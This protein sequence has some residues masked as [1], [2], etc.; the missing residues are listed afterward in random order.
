MV[1][2]RKEAARLR[3]WTLQL[4]CSQWVEALMVSL[5]DWVGKET[6]AGGMALLS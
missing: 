4:L 1:V 6:T 5:T 3:L 2:E